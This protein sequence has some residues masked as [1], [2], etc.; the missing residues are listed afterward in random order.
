MSVVGHWPSMESQ[1]RGKVAYCFRAAPVRL[2]V[3]SG[4][5]REK[6]GASKSTASPP[7][8]DELGRS[9][10][11]GACRETRIR[12]Q[13]KIGRCLRDDASALGMHRPCLLRGLLRP[14]TA[15]V[16][17]RNAE[18]DQLPK[19]SRP[20]PD[21]S[22]CTG[23]GRRHRTCSTRTRCR[24]PEAGRAVSAAGCL[25]A[26]NEPTHISAAA[27]R[28]G[29]PLLCSLGRCAPGRGAGAT[30]CGRRDDWRP[31]REPRLPSPGLAHAGRP[32]LDGASTKSI[33]I[34]RLEMT[35]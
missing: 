8:N 35:S 26:R 20:T 30:R 3:E 10:E 31:F 29:H 18:V 19:A 1:Q 2:L 24:P 14:G 15:A 13:R 27:G 25:S 16:E 12:N 21:G 28:Q 4:R 11:N 23:L 5:S 9:N 7:S 34:S 33:W 22:N 17:G 6:T 32:S